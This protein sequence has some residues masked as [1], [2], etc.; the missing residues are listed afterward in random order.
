MKNEERICTEF[1]FSKLCPLQKFQLTY[2]KI[3]AWALKL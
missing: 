1:A 2:N 3:G